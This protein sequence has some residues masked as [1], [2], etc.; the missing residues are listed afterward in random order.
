MHFRYVDIKTDYELLDDFAKRCKLKKYLNN[1]SV[2]IMM[3]QK[4]ENSQA[5]IAIEDDQIQ[6]FAGCHQM[7]VGLWRVGD[8]MVS[9]SAKDIWTRS[10][11]ERMLKILSAQLIALQMAWINHT[12]GECTYITTTNAPGLSKETAGKSHKIDAAFKRSN[13]LQLIDE[14]VEL[15]G[16]IQNI[17]RI[18][19]EAFM[20]M[21]SEE[22]IFHTYEE[23]MIING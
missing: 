6:A 22:C 3:N 18:D 14:E 21:L 17:Y 19:Y 20:N 9:L 12:Y 4:S 10:A 8:R 11:G 2:D 15:Y 5:I 1:S 13:V 16:V 7:N 23:G